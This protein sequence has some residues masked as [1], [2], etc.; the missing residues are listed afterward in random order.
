MR[1]THLQV[2]DRRTM[3][4]ARCN[5]INL[6]IVICNID[7]MYIYVSLHKEKHRTMTFIWIIVCLKMFFGHLTQNI[8]VFV[9]CAFPFKILPNKYIDS[10]SCTSTAY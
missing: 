4:N 6:I 10:T 1:R 2:N 5:V 3:K 7:Y 8:A 9:D